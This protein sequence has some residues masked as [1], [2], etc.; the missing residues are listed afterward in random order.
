MVVNVVSQLNTLLRPGSDGKPFIARIAIDEE[1]VHQNVRS[2]GDVILAEPIY[3]ALQM[4]GFEG[5]AHHLVNH[6]ALP[7]MQQHGGS[8]F[9][10]VFDVVL[11]GY[12]GVDPHEPGTPSDEIFGR[13]PEGFPELCEV[14]KSYIGHAVEKS[15]RVCDY[16]ELYLTTVEQYT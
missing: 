13:L 7:Y 5:D 2:A 1:A 8:L 9:D 6:E 12:F 10:A 3:I 16:A 14:P 11:P 15:Q 4:A